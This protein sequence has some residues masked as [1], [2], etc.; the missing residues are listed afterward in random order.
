MSRSDVFG[1]ARALVLAIVLMARPALARTPEAIAISASGQ[2]PAA[3][4]VQRQLVPLLVET[5]VETSV[6]AGPRGS[7]DEVWVADEGEEFRVKVRGVERV[8]ENPARDCEERARIA[9]VL[10]ALV[11]DPPLPAED[12]SVPETVIDS[13]PAAPPKVAPPPPPSPLAPLGWATLAAATAVFAPGSDGSRTWGAGPALRALVGP[14]AQPQWDLSLGAAFVSPVRLDLESG[15]VRLTQVPL[16]LS[17]SLILGSQQVRGVVGAGVVGDLLHLT[18]T[19]VSQA[20]S[21]LRFDVGLR[22]HVGA[23]FRLGAEVWGVA[24]VSGIFFPRPYEFEV[25]PSGVVG[26]TPALW[27]AATFGVLFEIH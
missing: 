14:A 26:H 10:I 9:A 13:G 27:L 4:S 6:V 24:E 15:G 17:G 19:G 5:S 20:Q 1:P 7:V 12:A 23:R 11:V 21:S 8:I 16:D 2:C 25:S 18:G 3:E 22:S